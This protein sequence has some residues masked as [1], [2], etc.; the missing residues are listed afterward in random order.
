M[1]IL[2]TSDV[3]AQPVESRRQRAVIHALTP[4]DLRAGAVDR[5][6]L[7]AQDSFARYAA[8]YRD[9]ASEARS[10]ETGRTDG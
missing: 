2:L 7:W 8:T 10:P 9:L 4:D 3:S 1:V 6:L 5:M